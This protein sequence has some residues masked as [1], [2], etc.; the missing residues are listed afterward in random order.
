VYKYSVSKLMSDI[1]GRSKSSRPKKTRWDERSIHAKGIAVVSFAVVASGCYLEAKGRAEAFGATSG[2]ALGG[3][4]LQGI[5]SLGFQIASGSDRYAS[6]LGLCG[7]R[8]IA[9]SR[10]MLIGHSSARGLEMGLVG[11]Q[12]DWLPAAA[13]GYDV[14]LGVV[15]WIPNSN[16]VSE[17][18]LGAAARFGTRH[19][20]LLLGPSLSWWDAARAGT[21]VGASAEAGVRFSGDP[22]SLF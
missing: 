7:E 22:R 3:V 19:A 13:L 20:E 6:V 21:A 2:S 15:G 18:R 17:V 1:P 10:G 5:V 11:P 14:R 8:S 4:G 12:T 16:N 9:A